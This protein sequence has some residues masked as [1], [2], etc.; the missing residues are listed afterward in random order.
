MPKI[1][2]KSKYLAVAILIGGKSTRFGIDK[3]LFEI[4]GKSLVSYQLETLAQNQYDIFLVAHDYH[5][6][7]NYIDKIDIKNI[8]GFII[9]DEDINY[10]SKERHP[11]IG[12]YTAFKELNKLE[13]KKLFALPCD[14]PLIQKSVI[15]F[16][17]SQCKNFECCIPQ[18]E[19]GFLEPLLA[20]Y[21]IKK[22]LLSA[23]KNIRNESFKLINLIDKKWK[24]NYIPIEKLIQKLDKN[25]LSFIN[26]NIQD[27]IEKIEKQII[28]IQKEKKKN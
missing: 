20:I 7:Q 18:W 8:M 27:D 15:E 16:L 22:A 11:M 6:V 23:K 25:L 4:L 26:I 28:N 21:P 14:T 2:N 9:D 5:Q 24:T 19:N 12:L 10:I 3:G 1:K 17:I 13:Y